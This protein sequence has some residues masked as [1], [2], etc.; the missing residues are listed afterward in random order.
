MRPTDSYQ[1]LAD[2]LHARG[3]GN[4]LQNPELLVV[5]GQ[6]PA[7][8]NSNSFWVTKKSQNWFIGTW[9]PAVYQV[10]DEERL[11][12]ICESVFHS[13][14]TAIY[15]IEPGLAATLNLHRLTSAEMTKLQF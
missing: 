13:S 1:Y 8:P 7:M 5:S 10:K 4:F 6:N 14:T 2:C 11:C 3:I 15:H 12:D 9:L